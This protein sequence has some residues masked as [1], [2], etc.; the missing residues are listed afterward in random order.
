MHP[1]PWTIDRRRSSPRAPALTRPGATLR[2][3]ADT[4][5]LGAEPEQWPR[6]L[7]VPTETVLRHD[8]TP[9]A[10]DRLGPDDE[11]A[12]GQAFEVPNRVLMVWTGDLG[13]FGRWAVRWNRDRDYLRWRGFQPHEEILEVTDDSTLARL[14]GDVAVSSKNKELHGMFV[15]G[16]GSPYSFGSRGAVFCVPYPDLFGALAYQLAVVAINACEGGWSKC[17]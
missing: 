10:P 5:G 11:L 4:I 3:L 2:A 8:S 16:H 6:W 7:T 15:T 14:L 9:V 12:P 13:W 1:T 17:D